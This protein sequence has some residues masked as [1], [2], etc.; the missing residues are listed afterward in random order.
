MIQARIVASWSLYVNALRDCG[1]RRV[2]ASSPKMHGQEKCMLPG[3][4]VLA[5]VDSAAALC[6]CA[7]KDPAPT[8]LVIGRVVSSDSTR[9]VRFSAWAR[10]GDLEIRSVD[11]RLRGRNAR[12][13]TSTPAELIMHEGV[14]S[15]TFASIDDSP[16]LRFEATAPEAKLLAT[17]RHVRFERT[18]GRTGVRAYPWVWPWQ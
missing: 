10:G 14:T 15:V 17:G 6:N 11:C 18:A 2:R 4:K 8:A 7:P 1:D 3:L 13:V 16:E 9:P 5:L 12:L